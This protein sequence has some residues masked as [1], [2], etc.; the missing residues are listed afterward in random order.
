M[1][2]LC[3]GTQVRGAYHVTL[4]STKTLR[5]LANVLHVHRASTRQIPQ[6]LSAA[7]APPTVCRVTIEQNVTAWLDTHPA[8]NHLTP[9]TPFASPV[10]QEST[11]LM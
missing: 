4:D 3:L 2:I 5:H 8:C 10:R 11:K 9:I 7:T 1:I 6:V